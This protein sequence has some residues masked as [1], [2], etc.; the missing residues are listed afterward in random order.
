[1]TAARREP[2]SIVPKRGVVVLLASGRYWR[3]GDGPDRPAT[4]W[5]VENLSRRIFQGEQGAKKK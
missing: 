4:E 2:N 1:M 3:I 5:E